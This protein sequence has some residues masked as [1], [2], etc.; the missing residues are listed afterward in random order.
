MK[1]RNTQD[2]SA[3]GFTRLE[4]LVLC[5]TLLILACLAL[6]VLASTKSRS[7]QIGC[8]SN[9]R[10]IGRAFQ[11][12]AN[13]HLDQPPC[14][15]RWQDGGTY[16][17]GSSGG[18]FVAPSWLIA[19]LQNEVY[20]QF[21]WLSNELATPKILACP[22]DEQVVVAEN[23]SGTAEGGFL[24]VN[25]RNRAVS[26]ILGL[27]AFFDY[28]QSLLSGDRNIKYTSTS[29]C[30]GG[31]Q[32]AYSLIYNDPSFGWTNNIH[33]EAGNLLFSDGQVQ[34]VTKAGFRGAV[35]N[36]PGNGTSH[37]LSRH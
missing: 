37:Y 7:Q 23:F 15:T 6:P 13:D 16:G 24:H 25:Y 22:S 26:Y 10:Q 1:T 17:G 2:P 27:H 36:T 30:S 20:F 19:G 11:L 14:R 4:L 32:F 34:Y 35:T 29:G 8:F 12:W 9:L 33:G 21:Y 28:P 5:A 31:I 3:R 18:G